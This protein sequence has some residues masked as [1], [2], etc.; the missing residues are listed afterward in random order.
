MDRKEIA[1]KLDQHAAISHRVGA[2]PATRAQVWYLAGLIEQ[3]GDDDR[4]VT[5]GNTNYALTKSRASQQIGFAQAALESEERAGEPSPG[6]KNDPAQEAAIHKA[7]Q[8]AAKESRSNA[9]ARK[10]AIKAVM[11][12]DHQAVAEALSW[13]KVTERRAK[14]FA[15]RFGLE[16]ALAEHPEL[17]AAIEAARRDVKVAITQ[18]STNYG[19]HK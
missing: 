8:G 12:H 6:P 1:Q 16:P 9:K 13:T 14:A 17:A 11:R 2:E 10:D 19:V 7:M 3:L 5:S 18:G 4:F 15:R